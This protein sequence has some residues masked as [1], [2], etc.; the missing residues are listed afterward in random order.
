MIIAGVVVVI[1]YYLQFMIYTEI[2]F[3][4]FL[5]ITDSYCELLVFILQTKNELI[6]S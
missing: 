6:Y 5:S 2:I 4:I 1:V 3:N